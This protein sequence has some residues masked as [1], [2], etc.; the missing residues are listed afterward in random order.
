MLL[1][2]YLADAKDENPKK[3]PN[4]GT[5]WCFII[6]DKCDGI[7]CDDVPRCGLC[8]RCDKWPGFDW[9]NGKTANNK[10]KSEYLSDIPHS[11]KK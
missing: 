1:V 8:E 7:N 3:N 9:K 5:K 6:G 10:S 4:G 11:E 2:S